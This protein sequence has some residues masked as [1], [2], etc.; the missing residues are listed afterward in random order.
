MDGLYKKTAFFFLF[1][2]VV[3][4]KKNEKIDTDKNN[5]IL[6][7][8]SLIK[9]NS[10]ILI[11]SLDRYDLRFLS[12][13]EKLEPFTVGLLDSISIDERYSKYDYGTR[14]F[15]TFKLENSDLS[16]FKSPYKLN[17]IKTESY[18]S[19]I[20][21]I[22]FSNLKIEGDKAQ[23]IV[24]KVRGISSVKD[25]YYFRKENSRWIFARKKFLTMG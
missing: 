10:N 1:L 21:F 6:E 9:E 18:K 4:C 24:T 3:G 13:N 8:R 22:A 20:L 2:A 7:G 17:L 5:L 14:N 23:I 19:S 25:R 11:D 16:N 12:K 15:L